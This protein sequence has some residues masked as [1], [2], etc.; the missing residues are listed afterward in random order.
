MTDHIINKD[1]FA[2][3]YLLNYSA[4]CMGDCLASLILHS[5]NKK[6]LPKSRYAGPDSFY[7]EPWSKKWV[8][9]DSSNNKLRDFLNERRLSPPWDNKVEVGSIIKEYNFHPLVLG[10]EHELASFL[11]QHV[12]PEKQL[13]LPF[14]F[15]SESLSIY[16]HFNSRL[17]VQR[18]PYINLIDAHFYNLKD[19][20]LYFLLSLYKNKLHGYENNRAEMIDRNEFIKRA[21]SNLSSDFKFSLEKNVKEIK[22][23][24]KIDMLKLILDMDNQG[25]DIL[26]MDDTE[27]KNMIQ[28]ARQNMFEILDFFE[29]K[30]DNMPNFN[31]KK[32]NDI[33]D[34][35]LTLK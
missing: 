26:V 13:A 19:R 5:F 32:L 10:S 9:R 20:P 8:V 7:Y 30:I 3:S 22:N 28:T 11:S 14:L 4:G 15:V 34:R 33:Y 12:D 2:D 17:S 21:K 27:I 16:S 6:Y 35:V 25:L 1:Y 31:D 24:Y 18:L 29:I 23:Y